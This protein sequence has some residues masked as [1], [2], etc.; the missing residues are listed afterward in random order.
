MKYFT[1]QLWIDA[2]EPGDGEEVGRRYEKAF[3]AYARELE[4]L[5]DRLPADVFTFFRQADVHDGALLHLRI[6]D[7]DPHAP[8]SAPSA[9]VSGT[10]AQG[11]DGPWEAR[12]G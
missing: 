10:E 12:I 11:D 2:Q 4:S 6:R 9:D 3:S 1:K 5:R 7:V 8:E